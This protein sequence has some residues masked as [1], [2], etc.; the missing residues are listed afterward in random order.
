MALV[1]QSPA[2]D[3]S[4]M[5][6]YIGDV[7]RL[8]S[9][10][11]QE[12]DFAQGEKIKNQVNS[13]IKK[14]TH[15]LIPT[16]LDEAP[17]SDTVFI[18]LNAIYFRQQWLIP[19]DP[20]DTV[21]GTFYNNGNTDKGVQTPFMQRSSGMFKGVDLTI[22]DQAVQTL[23]MKYNDK[24]T[25]MTILLPN[26]RDGLQ[27]IL[28]SPTLDSDLLTALK[29]INDANDR[30]KKTNVLLPKFKFDSN[31]KL[32][33]I[34]TDMGLGHLFNVG[35]D[36]TGVGGDASVH[37]SAVNQKAF[38]NV[39]EKGTEAAGI[40][41]VFGVSRSLSPVRQFTADHP[42]LFLIRDMET[43]L[44]FFIGKVEKF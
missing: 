32:R 13:K 3:E 30:L 1:G 44:V 35:A 21:T 6:K 43:G 12:V 4:V 23:E 36:L 2:I 10:D 42:F 29:D 17:G 20:D 18:L 11:A 19:F 5:N 28:S 38:I 7:A 9:A 39:D 22:G 33:Q 27:K 25:T 16:V 34:L 40:S 26:E 15:G 24:K 41:T 8:Y 37:L 14:F 31:Y